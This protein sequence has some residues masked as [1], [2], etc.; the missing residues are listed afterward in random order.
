M[1][2]KRPSDFELF[3]RGKNVTQALRESVLR[4]SVRDNVAG[5]ADELD[6]ELDDADQRW[7][8]AW[9]PS[10]GDILRCKLGRTEFP[11][12]DFGEFEIDQITFNGP[13]SAV[14]IRALSA[15][16]QKAVRTREGKAFE[17][18]SLAKIIAHIAKKNHL[19]VVGKIRAIEIDRVTQFG[20]TD[21]AFLTRLASL[22]GYVFKIKGGQIVFTELASI[23]AAKP[24]YT[25]GLADIASYRVVDQIRDVQHRY[26]LRGHNIHDKS[27]TQLDE[28]NDDNLDTP[29]AKASADTRRVVRRQG[30]ASMTAQQR[31]ALRDDVRD[32]RIT[33]NIKLHQGDQRMIAGLM[34]SLAELGRLNGSYL[35]DRGIHTYSRND[36]YNTELEL[37]RV[38][39]IN[40]K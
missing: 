23:H 40:E 12:L 29:G 19:K 4:I 31:A 3:M 30:T 14:G 8:G 15:G 25:L 7:R 35:I 26:S 27:S 33:A 37:K 11:L 5:E 6:I 32:A 16:V 10:K 34:V 2:V 21:V 24:L 36:G 22:Y 39:A 1:D 13:P 20:E 17:K 38:R 28:D 18:T 9:Y